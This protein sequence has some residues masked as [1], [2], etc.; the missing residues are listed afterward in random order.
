MAYAES[1]RDLSPP[2]FEPRNKFQVDL[3]SIMVLC[4]GIHIGY[5]AG[6]KGKDG[7][8]TFGIEQVAKVSRFSYKFPLLGFQLAYIH[9]QLLKTWKLDHGPGRSNRKRVRYLL[10]ARLVSFILGHWCFSYRY[11][12]VPGQKSVVQSVCL[13]NAILTIWGIFLGILFVMLG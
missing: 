8:P 1:Y 3:L 12:R 13:I 11:H 7:K 10:K 4:W 5:F 2:F 9:F 6:A